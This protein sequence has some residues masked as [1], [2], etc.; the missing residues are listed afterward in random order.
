M[1]I[2]VA[3]RIK[4]RRRKN[5]AFSV[6]MVPDKHNMNISVAVL[7]LYLA[8]FEML[9]AIVHISQYF[10]A[11]V[12]ES[13]KN[14]FHLNH[15]QSCS[16]SSQFDAPMTGRWRSYYVN[17]FPLMIMDAIALTS[18]AVDLTVFTLCSRTFRKIAKELFLRFKKRV[19]EKQKITKQH[20][21][22]QNKY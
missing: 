22:A 18:Y 15:D 21:I 8:I 9:Y 16:L 2:L 7:S 3:Y 14:N 13:L 12:H 17:S 19:A 4:S 1:N 10:S 6:A 5:F 11:N 20:S